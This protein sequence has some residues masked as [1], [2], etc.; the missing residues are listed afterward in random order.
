MN[1]IVYA[2]A[3]TASLMQRSAHECW[4]FAYC[5]AGSGVLTHEQGTLSFQQDEVI[6]IPPAVNHTLAVSEDHECIMLRASSSSLNLQHPIII[7]DDSN[8]FL[9][10]AFQAAMY[11][12]NTESP[13]RAA[14]LMCYEA[15]ISCYLSAY[16]QK[17]P[18]TAIACEIECCILSN[19]ADHSFK[20]D[21]YLSTLPF[22][23]GYLRKVF[24][25]TCGVTPQQYLIDK[26]LQSAAEILRRNERSLSV[27]DVA[28]MCGFR[29]PLYFSKMFKKKFGVAPSRYG[30]PGES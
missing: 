30:N 25:M 18:R 27:G 9:R 12:F 24:Q 17:T 26:R 3:R 2:G 21:Q 11:H 5:M 15:L 20:L 1:H 29:D 16:Q 22:S 14:L 6:V 10:A 19:Y 23:R 7:S 8:H 13:E 4:E 28:S